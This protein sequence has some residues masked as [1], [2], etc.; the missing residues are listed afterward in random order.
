MPEKSLNDPYCVDIDACCHRQHR[1]LEQ[2]DPMQLDLAVLTRPESV[3]WLTGAYVGPLFEM[4]AAITSGGKVTLVVPQH[5]TKMST[6][7]DLV[8]PYDAQL[9]STLRDD[10]RRASTDVLLGAIG[11]C[12]KHVGGELAYLSRYLTEECRTASNDTQ[13]KDV[14]EALL[15]LRR[16]KDADELRMLARANEANRAMYE[17]ARQAIEP[18]LTELELFSQLQTVATRTLGEPLTYFGQD[19]QV[20]S[21]G[22]PPRN[23]PAEGGELWILDLGVGF[24]GYRSDNCRAFAVGGKAD[25]Q[26]LAA[27][28]AISE[29]FAHVTSTVKPGTSCKTLYEEVQQHL[30]A[31]EPWSFPHHLGHGVGLSPHETPRLNPNW[32]DTFQE[33]DFFTVE[34]GLYHEQL[35][36]GIR[37]EQNYLVSQ[38]GV[39]LLTDWPLEL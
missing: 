9:L 4:A 25:E 23:R 17:Y 30:G 28:Q 20:N 15:Q 24:R 12:P 11:D 16:R 3:Q 26:Q 1:L 34:P 27:H 19:F 10:Q 33:G 6:A 5:A 22:G 29:V 37:L 7:A 8:V 38:T 39:E 14:E 2:L 21:M 13:W 35:R 18:G 36:Y 32:D 31:H